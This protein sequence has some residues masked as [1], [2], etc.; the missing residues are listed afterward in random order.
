MIYAN[1]CPDFVAAGFVP[2]MLLTH[3]N[4]ENVSKPCH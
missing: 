4:I 1:I 2:A 3:G